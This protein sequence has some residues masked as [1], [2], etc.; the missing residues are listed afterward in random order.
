MVCKVKKKQHSLGARAGLLLICQKNIYL[1]R[2]WWQGPWTQGRLG[3]IHDICR[4]PSQ[5]STKEELAQKAGPLLC[6]LT[7]S[8]ISSIS[9]SPIFIPASF[10]LTSRWTSDRS[11]VSWCSVSSVPRAWKYSKHKNEF[12]TQQT[13][14]YRPNNK[15]HWVGNAHLKVGR[16]LWWCEGHKARNSGKSNKHIL[17]SEIYL[18]V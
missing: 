15:Q 6:S 13:S 17:F 8:S 14:M 10:F 12:K 16:S 18:K 9:I 7:N 5:V 2:Q 4:P 3:S 1:Y 11:F